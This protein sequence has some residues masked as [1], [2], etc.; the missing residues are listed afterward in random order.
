MN[1]LQTL[2]SALEPRNDE[3]LNYQ[4]NIDN[5]TR[6][7]AK[8][9]DEHV[10]NPAMVEFRDG[11]IDLVESSKTEQ[12]KTIIIRDVIADQITELEASSNT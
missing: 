11:L 5:Y 10:N 9:N 4:I 7:I 1:K 8:I 3:I 6:A 2:Q 12:L